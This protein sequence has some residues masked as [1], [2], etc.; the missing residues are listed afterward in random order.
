MGRPGRAARV[1]AHVVLDL[2]KSARQGKTCRF[3]VV[4]IM[5]NKLHGIEYQLKEGKLRAAIYK[6]SKKEPAGPGI[7]AQLKHWLDEA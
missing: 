4:L 2:A 5:I 1:A 6:S 7:F 3:D